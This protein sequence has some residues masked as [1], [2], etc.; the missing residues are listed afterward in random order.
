MGSWLLFQEGGDGFETLGVRRLQSRG[1]A[2]LQERMQ[3]GSLTLWPVPS[4]RWLI[5]LQ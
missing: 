4:P 1:C 3:V 5:T 2:S